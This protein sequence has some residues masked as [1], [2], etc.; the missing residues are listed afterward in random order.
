MEHLISKFIRINFLQQRKSEPLLYV[1]FFPLLFLFVLYSVSSLFFICRESINPSI[2]FMAWILSTC[3]V[4]RKNRSIKV[5]LYCVFVI[6]IPIFVVSFVYDPSWDG[7]FYHKVCIG[8][9]KEEHWNPVYEQFP[10]VANKSNLFLVRNWSSFYDSYPKASWIISACI[11]TVFGTIESAK[12][13]L[14]FSLISVFFVAYCLLAYYLKKSAFESFIIS[15]SFV[16]TPIS[17]G[18]L[19]TFYNDAFLQSLFMLVCLEL[20][21]IYNNI[22]EKICSFH[23][24]VILVCIALGINLKYSGLLIMFIPCFVFLIFGFL[25]SKNNRFPFLKRQMSFYFFVVMVS[26]VLLGGTS[27]LHNMK[28]YGNP[29]YT[30]LGEGKE[31]VLSQAV[32]PC[33]KNVN[34]FES[35][36][37]SIFAECNNHNLAL[38]IPFS[39]H[40]SEYISIFYSIENKI[41]GWGFLYSG[42]FLISFLL[43]LFRAIRYRLDK[44]NIYYLIIIGS[45]FIPS[46]FVQD[47][48][49]ARYWPFPFLLCP[50]VLYATL[51]GMNTRKVGCSC[52]LFSLVFFNGL[53]S[54][55]GN[56]YY[57]YKSYYAHQMYK[58]I[59]KEP[60]NYRNRLILGGWR[61][62]PAILE[63]LVYNL[64]D[65]G[66]NERSLPSCQIP[67]SFIMVDMLGGSI[68]VLNK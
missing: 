23:Y 58:K 24:L 6:L 51:N 65:V 47:L 27:Y 30:L 53:P 18:Q 10:N 5:L 9:L 19:L 41:A 4:L 39:L 33:F 26:V 35:L 50:W 54:F 60:D 52:V 45:I 29:F 44:I 28:Y 13:Y 12:C 16:F 1:A 43:F 63:G 14:F 56:F 68:S 37:L 46:I 11:Y 55:V 48:S 17:G 62:K 67:N 57:V 8:L 42:I 49:C 22:E 3:V 25:K 59:E 38:K 20:L 15:F 61:S 32:P 34:G 64:H 40:R 31:D 7:N 36:V 2:F 66:V 21:Y